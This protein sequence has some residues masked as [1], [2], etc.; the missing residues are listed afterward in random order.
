MGIKGWKIRRRFSIKILWILLVG[1]SVFTISIETF[2]PFRP[3]TVNKIYI[4]ADGSLYPP[5]SP[6]VPIETVDKIMYTFTDNINKSIVVER[7]HMII[8]GGGFT[9]HG[10]RFR[11]GFTLQNIVNVTIKNTII[12]AFSTAIILDDSDYNTVSGNKITNNA[13]LFKFLF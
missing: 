7:S 12:N 3:K 5:T 9:M 2:H 1:A 6:A 4:R 11:D 8:D 10:D 13:I